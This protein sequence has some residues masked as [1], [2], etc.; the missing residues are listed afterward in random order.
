MESSRA[1]NTFVLFVLAAISSSKTD[2][3][4][5]QAELVFPP[6]ERKPMRPES[7]NVRMAT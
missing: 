4:R 5:L 3:P 7:W 6:V 1:M 2:E